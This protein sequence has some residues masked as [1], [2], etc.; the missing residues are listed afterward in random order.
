MRALVLYLLGLVFLVSPIVFAQDKEELKDQLPPAVVLP[1][2][3]EELKLYTDD[4]VSPR[5]L[6]RDFERLKQYIHK[7]QFNHATYLYNQVMA[8]KIDLR[9]RER[10]HL[11]YEFLPFPNFETYRTE[12]SLEK[13]IGDPMY[14]G[15]YV[16]MR[17]MVLKA[18][19]SAFQF[20]VLEKENTKRVVYVYFLDEPALILKD[21]RRYEL[22][23]RYR[24]FD[25]E[26]KMFRFEGMAIK[27]FLSKLQD[28][29]E[30]KDKLPPAVILP[31]RIEDIK[32]YT[33]DIP[34]PSKV[35]PRRLE[36]DFERLK[37]YIHK[38]QFNRATYL[39]N[40]IMALKIDLRLRERFYLLYQFLPRPNFETYRT[41]PNL[42]KIIGDPMYHGAYVKM[43]GMVLKAT[44]SA[45]QFNVLERETTKRV[46]YVYFLDKPA[47]ILKDKRR[48]ELLARYRGF[49][50]EKKMFRFEGMAIKAFK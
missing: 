47:L 9:L 21:K 3:I 41:E 50:E 40:Q 31:D 15:A 36:R 42:E 12:P 38:R 37:Q 29:E 33:D 39:Y 35:S 45:F 24:G 23:A 8:L 32:L 4:M 25:G 20:N 46:V 1:D 17:G 30:L 16:K 44:P 18:T 10:F 6:E 26:K 49:D 14:H 22:L 13:I 43:R 34:Y 48:Y 2:K 11:L 28:K 7:R 19:P 27:A 5:R